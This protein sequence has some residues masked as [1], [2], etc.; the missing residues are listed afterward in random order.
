MADE[1]MLTYGI[2]TQPYPLQVSTA[3]SEESGEIRINVTVP[4]GNT[5]YCNEID[6][7]IPTNAL[8]KTN[9]FTSAC[10]S[11]KWTTGLG[12]DLRE[13]TEEVNYTLIRFATKDSS[14]NLINYLL[15]FS[16][17]IKNIVN[18]PT[19]I[20]D[21]HIAE[22]S[23]QDGVN[24]TEK[25]ATF[26]VQISQPVFYLKNFAASTAGGPASGQFSKGTP[27]RLTWDGN[28]TIYRVR[29][30][31]NSALIYE[32]SAKSVDLPT[33]IQ[34]TTTFVLEAEMSDTVW[35]QTDYLYEYLTISI[36]NP[37]IT[38]SSSAVSG[39]ETVGGNLKVTGVVSGIGMCPPYSIIMYSGD[40][41]INCYDSSGKGIK[42]TPYEGWQICNG[43]NGAPNL[44]DRFI[45]GAGIAP[46]NSSGGPD[47]HVHTT[48]VSSGQI[49][50]G[51]AGNHTHHPPAAWYSNT[52]SSGRGITIVDRCGQDVASSVTST[53]G[54]HTHPISVATT[55]FISQ[56]PQPA[57]SNGY[58][59]RPMY[60]AL[61]YIMRLPN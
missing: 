42:G 46:L 7:Y 37:D 34:N 60:Y 36:I 28:A 40:V 21:L 19:I 5:V 14:Y 47:N 13:V 11:D 16:I 8:S 38:P 50:I 9:E 20:N 4:T 48:Y 18:I 25:D 24:Y 39:N 56:N 54:D 12:S 61:Y 17:A 49:T 3:G 22:F 44:T 10:S 59:N 53:D 35:S 29:T 31:S 45:V 51:N 26:S 33:G 32:G 58:F 30:Q 55:P 41:S 1:T 6:I 57:D 27:I 23:S 2:Y 43:N 52:A 15:S